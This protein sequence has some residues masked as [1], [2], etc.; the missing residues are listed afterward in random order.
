MHI[1]PLF[2]FGPFSFIRSACMPLSPPLHLLE[3]ISEKSLI[4][5]KLIKLVLILIALLTVTT[6][7]PCVCVLV[8]VC[9]CLRDCDGE[10]EREFT[11]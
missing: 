2:A 11:N 7:C 10:R 3:R 6:V 1:I 5:T 8:H 4:V 9:V